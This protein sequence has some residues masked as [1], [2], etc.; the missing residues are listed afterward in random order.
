[1]KLTVRANPGPAG[2]SLS[3]S[4]FSLTIPG[5]LLGRFYLF[6]GIVAVEDLLLS[7]MINMGLA[8][9]LHPFP[10]AI[11]SFAVFL[12]LGHSSL[13]AQREVIPFRFGFLGGHLACLAAA[14]CFFF[15]A[16]PALHLVGFPYLLAADSIPKAFIGLSIPPLALACVPLHAWI[17]VFRVTSPL[18]VYAALAG[19]C[20]GILSPLS[21]KFWSDPVTAPGQFLQIATFHSVESALRFFMPDVSANA[22]TYAISTPRFSV[23][24]Y[25]PCSGI[26]G[27]A[28]VL[29]FTSVWLWYCRKQS[30]FPQ[31][32]LLIPCALGSIWLL[33]IVRI[34]MLILIGDRLSPAVAMGGFHSEAGW[35]TF[36][37]VALGF[38]MA[39]ER[40]SWVR[41]TPLSVPS[42]VGFPAGVETGEA[43]GA[44]EELREEHGES[45]ATGAYLLPFLAILA[46]SLVS[47]AASG[48]F[49]WLYPLRFVVAAIVLWHFRSELKKLDWRFGWVAPLTGVA[50]FLVWVAPFRWAHG[51]SASPLGSALAALSPAARLAWIAFRVAAAVI[52]VPIAEELAFRGYLARRLVDREFDR[53]SF[54][55]LTIL[56]VAVS[57]VAF[58]L[59]HGQH[60]MVGIVAGLAYALALRWRGRMGDAF[61]AHAV[62]NLLLAAWVLS[63][64]DWAQW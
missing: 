63:R 60:W 21:Q 31:A 19:V 11:M 35:I 5:H 47:K 34:S 7:R 2:K 52:T 46:A 14:V 38:S 39:T 18:W 28:L 1:M 36:T 6:A 17:R 30:R 20:A 37:A 48:N 12:G 25:A 61:A 3:Q 59:M 10:F 41:K 26:Q 55:R 62:S 42:P 4:A 9:P 54:S 33:N 16:L 43:A 49:E 29:G 8:L 50:V 27:L 22:A 15:F 13:K 53:I 64:G 44:R 32:L 23:L 40:L 57:S 45:P 24:I 51:S 56:P 58:G